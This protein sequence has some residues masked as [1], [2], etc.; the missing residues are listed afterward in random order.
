MENR[1]NTNLSGFSSDDDLEIN[2]ELDKLIELI[3]TNTDIDKYTE[4]ISYYNFAQKHYRKF[5]I[6]EKWI[7]LLIQYSEKYKEK[8]ITFY[9]E[10]CTVCFLT[11]NCIIAHLYPMIGDRLWKIT[12]NFI[13]DNEGIIFEKKSFLFFAKQIYN[14]F[15]ELY[16]TNSVE[17]CMGLK[18]SVF[19]DYLFGLGRLFRDPIFLEMIKVDP[20]GINEK[21]ENFIKLNGFDLESAER[22]LNSLDK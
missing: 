9:P 14:N 5:D 12:T 19:K 16:L 2:K 1:N 13:N 6:M 17:T 11:I 7:D 15:N 10:K 21:V 8:I 22:F 18:T 4:L 3:K 20:K